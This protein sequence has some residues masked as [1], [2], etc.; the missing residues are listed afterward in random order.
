MGNVRPDSRFESVY[1]I[2]M[3]DGNDRVATRSLAPGFRVYSE[4]L[5][6][7]NG[8][9][10]RIW[11][12][13]RSKLAAAILKG[14]E[15][16]PVQGGSKV[17]YLGA[18]T[19]TTSSHVSDIVG[20]SGIVFCVEFAARVMRELVRVCS[21]RPNMVPIMADAQVPANYRHIVGQ[22][23]VVYCDVAQPEQ[24]KLLAD[25]SD[26]YLERGGWVMLAVKARS[27]DVTMD[28][29]SVFK[30]EREVLER[31]GFRIQQN[32]YLAPFEKDHSMII[33]QLPK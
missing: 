15:I 22:V 29:S 17:L 21:A 2:R 18:S 9:E 12:P 24:A 30:Q 8:I 33:A 13:F 4:Q 7:E 11:N 32:I 26:M 31:R 6:R 5:I 16:L 27:V 28:P 14:L 23:N 25:N 19:G 3:P 20:T 10:Y 1:R